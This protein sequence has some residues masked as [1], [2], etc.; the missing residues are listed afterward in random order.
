ML[1]LFRKPIHIIGLQNYP[2]FTTLINKNK[3]LSKE[4]FELNILENKTSLLS[5]YYEKGITMLYLH[6]SPETIQ[7]DFQTSLY[8]SCLFYPFSSV[9]L[10]VFGFVWVMTIPAVFSL[11][12]LNSYN[13]T[14]KIFNNLCHRL[15]VEKDGT[16]QTLSLFLLREKENKIK[17][18]KDSIELK[19][20][21]IGFH[22]LIR[23]MYLT[24]PVERDQI[25]FNINKFT[26]NFD[27]KE[28]TG[29]ELKDLWLVYSGNE[30]L[31]E[32]WDKFLDI[33][34]LK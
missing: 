28:E 8:K 32:S 7:S 34:Q 24:A 20:F 30:C 9:L 5:E 13:K 11:L 25:A 19:E 23:K 33:F 29:K 18:K 12:E 3:A 16:N 15:I 1:K 10:G 21:I 31:I 2:H 14:R 17:I 26:I 27:A 4:Y 6:N 22:P